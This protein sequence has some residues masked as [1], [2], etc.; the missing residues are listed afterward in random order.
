MRVAVA[1]LA[2]AA[3]VRENMLNVLSAGVTTIVPRE[4]P[5]SFGLDLAIMIELDKDDLAV[6]NAISIAVVVSDPEDKNTAEITGE[7]GWAASE[8][9]PQFVPAP[10][11]L[12]ELSV[13]QP[14]M[15][16]VTL[17][18]GPLAPVVMF[19]N[20]KEVGTGL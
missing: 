2:D 6:D 15:Y 20:A 18:V 13:A 10:M 4:Y 5:A 11:S 9:W 19:L 16:K 17:R 8:L 3:T 14:G 12:R 1:A 7:L